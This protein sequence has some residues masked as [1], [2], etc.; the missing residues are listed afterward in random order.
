MHH[1]V[2]VSDRSLEID[3]V[4]V[5]RFLYGTAW[6]EDRTQPLVEL[7]LKQGF[8]GIDT[9]NQ[10]RHYHEA[11]VGSAIRDAIARGLVRRDELFLQTKF[12]FRPGQD[13]RLPYDPAAPVAEQVEQSFASSLEHLGVERIDSCLLHGPMQRAGLSPQDWE[14]WAAIERLHERGR[15]RLIGV[16]N[17]TAEQLEALCAGARRPPQFVQ[18]R[19]YAILGWDWDVREVCA[20]RGIVYQG[21]SLLTANQDVLAHPAVVAI[22]TRHDRTTCQIIFRFAL[23]VGMICLT[24]TSD[25]SHMQQDLSVRDFRLSDDEVNLIER[26]A[27]R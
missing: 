16:S 25:P 11:A 27:V 5:P 15:A 21:F 8:R 22:A 24:G 18:N 9:A 13:H 2:R 1:T 17:M 19:C 12:T 4:E 26:I 23:Q 3:G 6:K 20:A 10:R 7:A 14:A